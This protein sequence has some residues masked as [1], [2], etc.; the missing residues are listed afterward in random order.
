MN[1]QPKDFIEIDQWLHERNCYD[2][3][4]KMTFF[5]KYWKWRTV[6]MWRKKII[7]QQTRACKKQLQ[8]R[9]FLIHPI[10]VL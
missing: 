4:K 7:S 6:I 9:L 1:G 5:T 8:Q 2:I 3:I 10:L